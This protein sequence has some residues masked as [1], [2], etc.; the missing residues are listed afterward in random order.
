[1][2]KESQEHINEIAPI[3]STAYKLGQEQKFE[4]AYKTLLPYFEANEIPTYFEQPCGW[5]IYRYLKHEEDK[6]STY[7]IRRALFYYLNFFICR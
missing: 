4:E 5:A 7:D 2:D 6:I 3:V 1:M